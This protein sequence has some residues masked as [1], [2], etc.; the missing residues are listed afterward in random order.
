M[1]SMGPRADRRLFDQP[2]DFADGVDHA[3]LSR[4]PTG[5]HDKAQPWDGRRLLLPSMAVYP[6]VIGPK[7]RAGF[8][9][10]ETT[11]LAADIRISGS[12]PELAYIAM[13]PGYMAAAHFDIYFAVASPRLEHM[14]FYRRVLLFSQW[15]EPRPYPGLTAKFGCMGPTFTIP[16]A[17]RGAFRLFQVR[18]RGKGEAVW[19]WQTTDRSL[20]GRPGPRLVTPRRKRLRRRKWFAAGAGLKMPG[21]VIERGLAWTHPPPPAPVQEIVERDCLQARLGAGHRKAHE[22]AVAA[23]QPVL[24]VAKVRQFRYVIRCALKLSRGYNSNEN[25]VHSTAPSVL[26]S[27]RR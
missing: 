6:E 1:I 18:F 27:H 3:D 11:R 4:R 21:A 10:L 20:G 17:D 12:N 8:S 14:A 5:R 9:I 24:I 13:R 23:I 16:R 19:D 2:Y 7:L 26:G 25:F 22:V 15:C